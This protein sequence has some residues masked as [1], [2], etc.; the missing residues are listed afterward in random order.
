VLIDY[1]KNSYLYIK[2]R[3]LILS[4]IIRVVFK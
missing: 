2:N 1:L 4:N 3:K